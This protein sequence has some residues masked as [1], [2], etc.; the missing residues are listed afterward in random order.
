M[1]IDIYYDD[2]QWNYLNNTTHFVIKPC[3]QSLI[4]E[5]ELQEE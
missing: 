3:W 4:K 5:L 1:K 2:F